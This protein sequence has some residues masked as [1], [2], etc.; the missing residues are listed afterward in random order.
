M[1]LS[2]RPERLMMTRS[3]LVRRGARSIRPAMAW[4]D[5]RAGMMP[6][7]RARM[8][9]ASS[10]AASETAKYSGAA[11]VGEPGVFGADG[12]IIEPGGNGMRGGDLAVG[13]LQ[14]VSV[15]TLQH[16]RGAPL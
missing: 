1:S 7:R 16:H 10:A 14:D 4:A 6:S 8:R 11:L 13:V 3:F 9:A 15:R 5:S 12:G 2:P